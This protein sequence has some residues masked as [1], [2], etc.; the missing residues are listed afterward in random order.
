MKDRCLWARIDA[1]GT[2]SGAGAEAVVPWWS[3]TK[4]AIAATALRLAAAGRLDLDARLPDGPFT[5]R[6]LLRHEARLPDYGT[7]PPY[8]AAVARGLD[9]WPADEL[10][11]RTA[12]LRTPTAWTYSNIGYLLARRALERSE[13]A[14]LAA[15]LAE[16]LLAPADLVR[17]RMAE[18]RADMEG[19]ALPSP[20]YHPGWVYHGCLIGPVADAAALLRALLA[21]PLLDAASRRSLVDAVPVG[22]PP[23]GRPW[24]TVGYGLGLMTGEMQGA[25]GPVAALG[26]SAG[27]PGSGGAVYAF[28]DLPGA[29]TVAVFGP[30]AATDACEWRA[31]ALAGG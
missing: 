11:A 14:P 28:P 5:L 31:L 6:Q 16:R 15:I 4:T 9:P 24:R 3:F 22:A 7:F 2:V 12:R 27:G 20:G 26:H 1:D 30:G 13:G 19:T 23:P 17:T 29:P 8:G 21:G 25:R 10:L 18:T